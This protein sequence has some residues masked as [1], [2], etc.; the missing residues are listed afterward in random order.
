MRIKTLLRLKLL[1]LQQ[2]EK[3]LRQSKTVMRL[4]ENLQKQERIREWLSRL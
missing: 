2:Q 1:V 4:E 3:R